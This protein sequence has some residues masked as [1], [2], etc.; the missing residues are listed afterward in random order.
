MLLAEDLLLLVTEDETGKLVVGSTET[1][2]GLAGA[3][4]L[5]LSLRGAVEITEP[6]RRGRLRIVPDPV[7]DGPLD[8]LLGQALDALRAVDGRKPGQAIDALKK[9]LPEQIRQR[10]ADRGILRHERGRVLGIFPTDRWPAVDSSHERQLRAALH[11]AL[12]TG[13]RPTVETGA[14]AALLSAVGGIPKALG[15]TGAEGRS[16]RRRGKELAK[17]EWAADSV[18]A[19]VDAVSAATIAAVTAATAAAT[20]AGSS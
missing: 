18:R 15:L 1:Q 13:V 12:V 14:V 2:L 10:L 3:V 9:G 16:A 8:P 20:A 11:D 5:E 6:G 17:A 4:L 19:A 7:L